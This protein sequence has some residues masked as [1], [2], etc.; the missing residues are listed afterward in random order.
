MLILFLSWFNLE[1]SGSVCM[2]VFSLGS[3]SGY[4]HWRNADSRARMLAACLGLFRA[5]D[6]D[7]TWK[8][9]HMCP[10]G[11]STGATLR[12][13]APCDGGFV[14]DKCHF[15]PVLRRTF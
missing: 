14:K 10:S 1:R 4:R 12:L 2:C 7:V 8:S 5:A 9:C 6:E 15:G 3:V 11:V 13:C